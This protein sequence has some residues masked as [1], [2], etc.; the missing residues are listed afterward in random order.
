M[1]FVIATIPR[2]SVCCWARSACLL[3][4]LLALIV[5]P[6]MAPTQAHAAEDEAQGRRWFKRGQDLFVEGR[7][8]EAAQA[9]ETGYAAAPRTAFLL[10]IAHSYRRA[11]DLEKAKTYYQKL[12]ELEPNNPQRADVEANIKSIDDALMLNSLPPPPPP[13]PTVAQIP[14]P[15]PT[16]RKSAIEEGKPTRQVTVSPPR[17]SEKKDTDSVLGKAWFWALVVGIAAGAG[18]ATYAL[19]RGGGGCQEDL[20]LSE[21][22]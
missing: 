11:G 16:L 3:V 6:A 7:Y 2:C 12:L 19:T 10:N 21:K 15:E 14:A 20:C 18:V 8:L 13:A 22:P 4:S 1:P 17:A 9:F 5:A